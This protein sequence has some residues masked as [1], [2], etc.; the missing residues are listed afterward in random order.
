MPR[1]R[2]GEEESTAQVDIQHPV[3]RI[4]A[5][6]EQVAPVRRGYAS[7]VDEAGDRPARRND[8]R[9]QVGVLGNIAK[10]RWIQGRRRA[11][12]FNLRKH[13][14]DR[15]EADIGQ[16]QIEAASG[17]FDRDGR[18]NTPTRASNDGQRAGLTHEDVLLAR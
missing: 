17:K 6:R 13:R 7:I 9:D 12:F 5:E 3:E 2:L 8:A 1:H 10:I 14:F 4:S 16:R 18:A 11:M 15:I